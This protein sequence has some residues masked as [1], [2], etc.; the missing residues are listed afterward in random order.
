MR[1]SRKHE[2]P[3]PDSWIATT[4]PIALGLLT[5]ISSEIVLHHGAEGRRFL[6]PCIGSEIQRW[7]NGDRKVNGRRNNHVEWAPCEALV[8]IAG[9]EIDRFCGR[10]GDTLPSLGQKDSITWAN[11]FCS[12]FEATLSQSLDIEKAIHDDL[13]VSK[14]KSYTGGESD[15]MANGTASDE[16]DSEIVMLTPFGKGSLVEKR[17]NR[18]KTSD[19]SGVEMTV[20]VVRLGFGVLYCPV[21]TSTEILSPEEVRRFE[22]EKCKLSQCQVPRFCLKL[23]LTWISTSNGDSVRD[24][25]ATP[26]NGHSGLEEACPCIKDSLYCSPLSAAISVWFASGYDAIARGR[27]HLCVAG[28][29]KSIKADV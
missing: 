14:R 5:D 25:L 2:Q 18:H 22:E 20:N 28:I 21:E 6:W 27:R 26:D 12:F 11:Y 23:F 17:V 15:R 9:R 1:V 8:R 16:L 19:G 24:R 3:F 7:C 4:A 13:L 29:I 10:L